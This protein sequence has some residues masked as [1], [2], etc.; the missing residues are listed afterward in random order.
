[1]QERGRERGAREGERGVCVREAVACKQ[2][3]ISA[4]SICNIVT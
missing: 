3:I 1:M 4:F 2:C